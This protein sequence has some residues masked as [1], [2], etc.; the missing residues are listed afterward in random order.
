MEEEGEKE[1][2]S[3]SKMIESKE[4]D[5]ASCCEQFRNHMDSM[6]AD[7]ARKDLSWVSQH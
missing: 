3:N 7:L 2:R 4:D 5:G 1:E 6:S